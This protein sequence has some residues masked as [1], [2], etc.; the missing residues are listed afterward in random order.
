[1]QPHVK[2]L[3]AASLICFLTAPSLQASANTVQLPT[4]CTNILVGKA[5]SA[6]GRAILSYTCDGGPY[7]RI[8][9]VPAAE[10]QAGSAV[11]IF[12]NTPAYSYEA[13]QEAVSELQLVG[14]IPQVP[15][16]YQ[17]IDLIGWYG[18]HWGGVNEHGVTLFEST[19]GGRPELV[20]SRGIF[21]VGAQTVAENSLLILALQ[22]AKT[23]REAISV[24]TL[25]AEEYGYYQPD[26]HG[27]N[28]SITDGNEV[29]ILEIFGPGAGWRHGDDEPGALWCAQRIPDDH[30]CVSANRS[31]IGKIDPDD[32]KT[33][34]CSRN[35]IT[36]AVEMGWWD[37]DSGAPFVWHEAY[38]PQDWLYCSLRE[39]RVLD[40]LA[41]S[42]GLNS[43][44]NRFPLSV[45]PHKPVTLL[46]IMAL[47]RDAYE[48]TRYDARENVSQNLTEEQAKWIYP[49]Y[50]Y[51][52]IEDPVQDIL[53]VHPERT[54]AVWSAF[55][56]IAEIDPEAPPPIRG[57]L[58]YGEGPAATTC[59]VPI[60]TGVTDVPVA[61]KET[62]PVAIDWVSA[63]WAFSLVHELARHGGWE[64]ASRSIAHVRDVA[65]ERLMILQEQLRTAT[66][67]AI[68]MGRTKDAYS[69][70]TTAASSWMST[71]LD[72]YWDLV[73]YLLF[74]YYFPGSC[75]D[76]LPVP[77]I[78]LEVVPQATS[79]GDYEIACNAVAKAEQPKLEQRILD[80][81]V[82]KI[83]RHDNRVYFDI[84]GADF[85]ELAV[86]EDVYEV[87]D[88]ANDVSNLGSQWFQY[89]YEGE[90]PP[91]Q[92]GEEG[93]ESFLR[94]FPYD[95]IFTGIIHPVSEF[96]ASEFD[97]L[98]V[99]MEYKPSSYV[100][101]G[102]DSMNSVLEEKSF[103]SN[104]LNVSSRRD[105]V[106]PFSEMV[107]EESG[108]SF[109]GDDLVFIK[110]FESFGPA[111][112]WNIYSV[113]FRDEGQLVQAEDG[114]LSWSM[115][116]EPGQRD[117]QL[118]L[119]ADNQSEEVDFQV[120]DI[121]LIADT[122]P[123]TAPEVETPAVETPAEPVAPEINDFYFTSHPATLM[124]GV[125]DRDKIFEMPLDGIPELGVEM[126]TDANGDALEWSVESSH[127]SVDAY[128]LDNKLYIAAKDWFWAGDTSV[129]VTLTDETGLEDKVDVPVVVFKTDKTRINADG[130]KEYYIPWGVELDINRITST[131]EHMRQYDKEDLGLLDR[132]VR[133]SAWRLM[134]YFKG[135]QVGSWL[136]ENTYAGWSQASQFLFVDNIFIELA[137]LGCDSVSLWNEYYLKTMSSYPAA[138][139]YS[140]PVTMTDEELTYFINEAHYRG[141]KI[142]VTPQI[143]ETFGFSRDLITPPSISEWFDR[144]EKIVSSHAKICQQTGV[145]GFVMG[146]IL[147]MPSPIAR[148]QLSNA[149]WNNIMIQINE[150]A[151]KSY[152]GPTI[153]MPGSF[154]GG[155]KNG[156]FKVILPLLRSVDIVGGNTNFINYPVSNNPTFAE[157]EAIISSKIKQLIEPV[158]QTLDKPMLLNEGCICSYDGGIMNAD[159]SGIPPEDGVYDGHEQAIW[160]ESLFSAMKTYP[161]IFGLGWFAW[162]LYPEG[163]GTGDLSGTPR[164][165]PAEQSIAE[166]YGANYS[167]VINIDGYFSDWKQNMVIY[168]G[169]QGA[170][171]TEHPIIS[172][173]Y[174]TKDDD[175]F[176]INI[177]LSEPI[178]NNYILKVLFDVNQDG[179]PDFDGLIIYQGDNRWHFTL[180]NDVNDWSDIRGLL[181]FNRNTDFSRI[182]ARIPNNILLNS[183]AIDVYVG[184]INRS[185]LGKIDETPFLPIK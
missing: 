85:S 89:T 101:V 37:P 104:D 114:R 5:A 50:R 70:V 32:P 54:L 147:Y 102:L 150:S 87:D 109:S 9:I 48:G 72:T 143:R 86:H 63:H 125:T 176:Y 67:Q 138:S 135:P 152:S 113:Q 156:G 14:C 29:W 127:Y 31:R 146:N 93:G 99:N 173:V 66:A 132:T 35:A 57:C 79:E 126:G 12:E 106:F 149:Q 45:R 6:T 168:S 112:E 175:Y 1:M 44:N 166:A 10:H 41:P 179:K 2:I 110:L 76:S 117:I 172:S 97:Q 130:V 169:N 105:Y 39:W 75:R 60:S 118:H 100:M 16:T 68:S 13:Y 107:S 139:Y 34:L 69:N 43:S 49:Y 123:V 74:T 137:N 21:G 108:E 98:V 64:S 15:E 24:I 4:S 53:N 122:Q 133:F 161:Y 116:L 17:Y 62:D 25:L 42:L 61:W 181:D 115:E 140:F 183:N 159:F 170:H 56:C 94:L 22:R 141:F 46:D 82:L 162:H 88:F 77:Q 55:S 95:N 27:E 129:T 167:P 184:I 90:N 171:T 134:E 96:D 47:H 177:N 33:F 185:S 18:S 26:F 142:I 36:L 151:K 124:Q 71:V 160:Y 158:Y 58:W 23:A 38:A 81:E 178:D 92:R 28:I 59:Y 153:Y 20:N 11:S 119:F 164:L 163:G 165:K 65:E 40:T 111:G 84:E 78:S 155:Y 121:P 51:S 131:E 144:Y 7:G 3:V 91:M 145:D 174:G 30:V 136:N 19:I 80:D 120:G 148:G 73:D 83:E 157:V 8:R 103:S 182:E 180:L 154:E 52:W 128:I